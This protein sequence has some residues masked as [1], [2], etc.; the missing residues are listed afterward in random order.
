[1][2]T[3]G[4][5]LW[6]K[7]GLFGLGF[8]MMIWGIQGVWEMG[9][10]R[11]ENP[12]YA[13]EGLSRHVIPLEREGQRRGSGCLGRFIKRDYGTQIFRTRF[14]RPPT[15]S[16]AGRLMVHVEVGERWPVIIN[17]IQIRHGR[18]RLAY[19]IGRRMGQGW[20]E[21]PLEHIPWRR[22]EL[23]VSFNH[24]RGSRVG[25]FWAPQAGHN[26]APPVRRPQGRRP[27]SPWNRSIYSPQYF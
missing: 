27:H 8:S 26:S 1:M 25:L 12:R 14:H 10:A 13:H 21:I 16:G 17:T 5:K 11:A 23:I 24:G 19:H 6:R 9:L 20:N 22:G 4:T 3:V 2:F 7:A 15:G 18:E